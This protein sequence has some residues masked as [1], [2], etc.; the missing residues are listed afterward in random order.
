MINFGHN[1][2]P[3]LTLFVV[4][5]PPGFEKN[6]ELLFIGQFKSKQADD[7]HTKCT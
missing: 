5:E 1:L 4:F 2:S 3:K 6:D 7:L